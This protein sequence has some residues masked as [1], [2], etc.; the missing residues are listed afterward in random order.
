MTTGSPSPG[1]P[2]GSIERTSP[3]WTGLLVWVALTLDRVT[4]NAH[5]L[6]TGTQSYR[7]TSKI[8]A[9]PNRAGSYPRR[10]Q[11]SRCLTKNG[12]VP[13]DSMTLT[14]SGRW[15]ATSPPPSP[16][17]ERRAFDGISERLLNAPDTLLLI[18]VPVT[19]LS[20]APIGAGYV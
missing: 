11:P 8:I 5:I 20:P 2:I 6:E 10:W 1:V 3:V 19:V 12:F 15:P 9:R 14:A 18:G 13:P 4:F 7:L 16:T 17:P